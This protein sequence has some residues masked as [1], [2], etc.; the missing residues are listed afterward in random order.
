MQKEVMVA[1]ISLAGTIAGSFGGVLASSKLTTYRLRLLENKVDKHNR[2]AERLERLSCCSSSR[3]FFS[4][5][6]FARYAVIS[7][8]FCSISASNL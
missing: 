1:L 5:A 7:F 3:C 4:S 8:F 2:F 6:S